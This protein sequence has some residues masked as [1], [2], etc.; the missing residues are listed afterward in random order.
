[1]TCDV[2]LFAQASHIRITLVGIPCGGGGSDS[3]D[4][5]PVAVALEELMRTLAAGVNLPP[6]PVVLNVEGMTPVVRAHLDAQANTIKSKLRM[7]MRKTGTIRALMLEIN[8]M[9][10]VSLFFV[11]PLEALVLCGAMSWL[12]Y[13]F[14]GHGYNDADVAAVYA[15]LRELVVPAPAPAAVV[16]PGLQATEAV[17]RAAADMQ[18]KAVAVATASTWSDLVRNAR[19]GTLRKSLSLLDAVRDKRLTPKDMLLLYG[20]P[21]DAD[22]EAKARAMASFCSGLRE[23]PLAPPLVGAPLPSVQDRAL[24]ARARVLGYVSLARAPCMFP[25]SP[26]LTYPRLFPLLFLL[27]QP[28]PFPQ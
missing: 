17:A 10:G 6:R 4:G 20:A 5:A 12:F 11:L 27:L 19:R 24:A 23:P 8:A 7:F 26:I 25:L 14:G 9:G 2:W 16:A 1:V 18:A 21:V 22:H 3:E 13:K 15:L 28:A